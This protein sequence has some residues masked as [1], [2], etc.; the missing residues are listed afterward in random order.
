MALFLS[1]SCDTSADG[2]EET[3]QEE[4]TEEESASPDDINVISDFEVQL[5]YDVPNDHQGSWVSLSRGP[6]GTLIASDQGGEGTYQITVT[7]DDN[8]DPEVDV[9][10]LILPVS[11]AQGL[12]WQFDY[13]YSNVNGKGLFRMQDTQDDGEY[14]ILEYLGGPKGEGEHG[15]HALIPTEDGDGMYVLNGNHTPPPDFTSSRLANWD[16]DFLLPRQWDAR[17][18]ARGILA[19]GGYVARINE[20]ASEWEIISA[21]YRNQYDAAVNAHGDLFTYDSDM[22]WDMGMPW[23]RPTRVLQVVSGSDYGWRSG[24]GKW[25]EYYEDSLPP[26]LNIGPGSPT[27]VLFGTDAAFPAKY[28]HAMF[29]LDWTFGTMYTIH[30]TPKGAGYEGEAEEFLSGTPLP[31]TDA[32]I[33]DDGALYFT[34]GGRNQDSKLYRVVYRGDE[35]TDPAEPEDNEEAR[36]ARELRRQLEAFHGRED[37]G[38]LEQAWPHLDNEDRILRH[39]ARVAIESQPADTWADRV[40]TEER[41]QARITGLVALARTGSDEYRPQALESL[42]ELDLTEL[43]AGQ[44]LGYL[45]A[46]SL[47]F[48]RMGDPADQEKSQIADILQEI[49]PNDDERVNKEV[50][51]LLVYLED[52]RVIDKALA[53]MEDKDEAQ[54]D[55]TEQ[56]NDLLSRNEDYGETIGEMWENPPPTQQLAYAFS[57]R[58]LADGWSLDQRREYFEFIN[59]ASDHEG[60]A[61]YTGFL[62]RMRD[63][64]LAHVSDEDQEELADV[65]GVSLAREPDFEITPPEGP[66]REWTLEEAVG[67]VNGHLQERDFEQGRNAF[68]AATCA[69]CHRFDGYGGNIGPDLTTVAQTYSVPDL[70][71]KIIDPDVY[72]S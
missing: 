12:N 65:I 11:G 23:Y 38:A 52:S 47:I 63:E 44:K 26:L 1:V 51:D 70:L 39:A 7:D 54:V 37:A 58:N 35:S 19:P 2:E 14:N 48:I 41:D 64:A 22:E 67:A 68:F 25:P 10:E 56:A 59:E 34:T 33:G 43:D 4:E 72:I 18:H 42:L 3:E 9:E 29:A 5:V 62:E 40:L 17:G 20:D 28:Q 16:E 50:I 8:G 46:M 36:Q 71:E 21:G 61:S 53:L 57:L 27:G 15:N 45:R 60:G 6:N 66:G 55:T 24:S 32:V 69:S 49:L 13:L 31:L 30:L